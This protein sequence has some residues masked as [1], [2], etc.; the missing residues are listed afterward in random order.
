MKILYPERYK[1]STAKQV[2]DV[3]KNEYLAQEDNLLSSSALSSTYLAHYLDY[4]FSK[5]PWITCLVQAINRF[6]KIYG[7]YVQIKPC[8]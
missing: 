6:A 2:A 4:F 5:V 3:D 8:H 7:A 1:T